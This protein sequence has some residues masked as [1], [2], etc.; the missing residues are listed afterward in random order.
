[1]SS[2]EIA[3]LTGKQHSHV[4]RDIEKMCSEINPPNLESSIYEHRGNRYTQYHLD[5]DLTLCLVAGYSAKL[6][7]AII[8]RWR[9]LE[10]KN[11]QQIPQTYSEALQLAANQAK[12]I[13]QQRLKVE[14]HDKVISSS[15]SLRT[16]E[17]AA[18]LGVSANKLNKLLRDMGVQRRVNG[19]WVLRAFYVGKGYD[20]ESTHITEEGKTYHSMKW[21]EKGRKFIHDLYRRYQEKQNP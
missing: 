13:E 8:K 7:M 6:R 5:K 15:G 19:R 3:D 12:L 4:K 21:T 10:N 18:E 16:T 9:E 11:A 1:M 20:D 2:R 14:Y 17:I